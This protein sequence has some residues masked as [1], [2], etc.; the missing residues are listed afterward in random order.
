MPAVAFKEQEGAYFDWIFDNPSGY[1]LNTP[2]KPSANYMVL[3]RAT[4]VTVS[5]YLGKAKDGGFT[6][7]QFIKVCAKS[8]PELRQWALAHG[9]HTFSKH[10]AHC[11][12]L[13]RLATAKTTDQRAE[14][15]TSL[16]NAER[17]TLANRGF[18]DAATRAAVEKAAIDYVRKQLKSDGFRVAD[19]QKRNCGYDL[20][21]SKGKTRLL[22]EV[23]G[24]DGLRPRFFLTRNEYKC[25]LLEAKWQL[26]VVTQAR[27]KPSEHIYTAQQMAESTL[28]RYG[29]RCKARQRQC[30]PSSLPG[31]TAPA[32]AVRV[33]SNV[34]LHK[35]HGAELRKAG[36]T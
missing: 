1:V 18:P 34:R 26:R 10:C 36:T 24:T 12:A 2:R 23:K 5:R 22:V 21:A 35:C 33:N 17:A 28:T 6:D 14:D 8:I 4:C 32:S 19:Y 29:R 13:P 16:L 11:A 31:L 15:V 30:V 27:R 25:S 9:A 3:H 20:L 7:R